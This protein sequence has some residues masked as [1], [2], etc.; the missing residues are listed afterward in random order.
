MGT[1][2]DIWKELRAKVIWTLGSGFVLLVGFSI[3]S[4]YVLYWDVNMP[5]TGLKAQFASHL[6]VSAEAI[7][8]AQESRDLINDK[9]GKI[10]ARLDKEYYISGVGSVGIFGG[11]ESY[12]RVNRRSDAKV[13]K[14]GDRVRITC[15]MEGKPESVLVVNGTFTDSNPDLLV[16]FSR[17]AAENLGLTSRVD[18]E[19]E[20]VEEE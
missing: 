4:G 6:E 7:Q 12:I 15:D 17:Q 14:D 8:S 16:S 19:L 1:F 13:Y 9:L 2:A 20:P 5:D 3:Q 11:D 10:L 18:V